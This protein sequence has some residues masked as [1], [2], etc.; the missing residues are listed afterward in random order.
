MRRQRSCVAAPQ[1]EQPAPC[2]GVPAR[3]AV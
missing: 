2:G 1:R 3:A